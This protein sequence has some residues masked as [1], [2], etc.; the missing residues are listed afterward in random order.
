[1]TPYLWQQ[2]LYAAAALV[3]TWVLMQITGGLRARP[4]LRLAIL[5]PV[6]FGL[7]LIAYKV[8]V[9]WDSLETAPRFIAIAMT[10]YGAAF[11]TPV[12]VVWGGW[13]S[14]KRAP[15]LAMIYASVCMGV[16]L[17]GAFGEPNRLQVR[18][19]SI[20]F[21]AWPANAPPLKVVHVSDLQTVGDC[22]RDARALRMILDLKPDL[23]VVTGDY[24]GGPPRN[25]GPALE[26]AREFLGGLQARLGVIVVNGHSEIDADREFIF[27]GLTNLTWLQDESRIYQLGEGRRL[28]VHGLD[29]HTHKLPWPRPLPGP[30]DVTMA[31][32]HT[33]D[34]SEDMVGH[35]IDLH[36][37][38]HTHGGQIVIPGYGAPVI[39]SSLHRRY[40]RGLHWFDDHWLNVCAGIGMEGNHAPRVRLF[41]PPEIC[42]LELSGSGPAR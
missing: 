11:W 3:P 31:V 12:A 38:G 40:A 34:V 41:C 32:T 18:T 5:V 9:L 13:R 16:A 20:A 4:A 25:Q 21:A 1:M 42:V 14:R 17:W 33:P 19:E 28:I 6:W 36:V 37:A 8:G 15:K 22:P 26:A 35:Q 30:G 23:I 2:A 24:A 27:A 29:V 39:L 10:F 7:C